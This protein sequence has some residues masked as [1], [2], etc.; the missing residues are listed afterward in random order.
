VDYFRLVR[1][2]AISGS[3]RRVSTNS[4]LVRA[5]ALLATGPIRVSVY[6]ELGMIPP[7]NPDDDSEVA[8][9]AVYRF[10]AQLRISDAVLISSPEY[11]HGVSGVL[12]NALDWVVSSGDLVDKPVALVNASP[13][14]THAQAALLETLSVMSAHVVP[15]ASITLPLQGRSL[16][17]YGIVDDRDLSTALRSAIAALALV[18]RE[19]VMR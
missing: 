2:L 8:H 17:A 16:D 15:T 3:L 4:A 18:A 9:P 10:R 13:R 7:F 5:A 12:K 6:D 14:A 1:I 11:A 19:P